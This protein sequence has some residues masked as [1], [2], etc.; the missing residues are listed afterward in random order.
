MAKHSVP[1]KKRSPSE[2]DI[3]YRAF[4]NKARIKLMG[5]SDRVMK[6]KKV[7]KLPKEEK[8]TDDKITTVKA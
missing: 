6:L 2:S 4:Q 1:K 7:N 8:K 3:R 5:M